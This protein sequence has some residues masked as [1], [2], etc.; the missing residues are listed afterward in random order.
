MLSAKETRRGS[1]RLYGPRKVPSNWYVCPARVPFRTISGPVP[2]LTNTASRS[3]AK[4]RNSAVTGISSAAERRSTVERLGDVW[5]FSIFDN[6][7]LEMPV[8]SASWPTLSPISRRRLRTWL[9]ITRPSCPLV[10]SVPSGSLSRAATV[11][12]TLADRLG[13]AVAVALVVRPFV[14]TLGVAA[15]PLDGG[16]FLVS[17]APGFALVLRRVATA[18]QYMPGP[19]RPTG[20]R[21]SAHL[22]CADVG[23]GADEVLVA[24]ESLPAEVSVVDVG[25]PA[26]PDG[27]QVRHE[28]PNGGGDLVAVPRE[29]GAEPQAG[30]RGGR[31]P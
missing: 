1:T 13:A 21:R 19:S 14:G 17:S 15:R 22:P 8:R 29:A 18:N 24:G 4:P 2:A 20:E 16:S 30:D 6:M 7:P 11:A 12:L 26:V 27:D 31:D 28:L 25:V 23:V 9:A 5:A 3:S 10:P